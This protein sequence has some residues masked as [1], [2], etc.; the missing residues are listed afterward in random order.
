MCKPGNFLAYY[1]LFRY[2]PQGCYSCHRFC[3]TCLSKSTNSFYTDEYS[4]TACADMRYLTLSNFY[5]GGIC[6]CLPG[7]LIDAEGNCLECTANCLTFSV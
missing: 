2:V 7:L 4:C 5:S 1:N 3:S 6:T